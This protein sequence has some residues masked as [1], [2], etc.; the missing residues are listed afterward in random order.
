VAARNRLSTR[1]GTKENQ[2]S[3]SGAKSPEIIP[4]HVLHC[5]F[6]ANFECDLQR[7][8]RVRKQNQSQGRWPGVELG[9]D[10]SHCGNFAGAMALARHC[11]PSLVGCVLLQRIIE[12]WPDLGQMRV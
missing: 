5:T 8:P 3:R 1:E 10:D 12:T 6:A 11:S 4:K 7:E 9:G 2:T